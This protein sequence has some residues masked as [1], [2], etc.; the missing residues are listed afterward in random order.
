MT[1]AEIKRYFK[2]AKKAGYRKV[3]VQHPDGTRLEFDTQEPD[4]PTEPEGNPWDKL[5]GAKQ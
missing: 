5:L 2:A 4:M 1:E 3:W